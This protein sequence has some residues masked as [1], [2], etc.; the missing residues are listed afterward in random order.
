MCEIFIEA[1]QLSNKGGWVVDQQS[2]ETIHSSYL[3]AHGMGIPVEDATGEVEVAESGVYNIWV[4]TRDWTAVWDVKDSAG[5]FKLLVDGRETEQILGTN[6][7]E[8]GWQKAGEVEL[9]CGIH[10]IGL[11]DLTGFNGRCDAIYMTTGS[12]NP[13]DDIDSIRQ[14]L[15]W[16]EVKDGGEYELIVAG[17]GIAGICTAL[18]AIRGGVNALLI[19]DREVLGGCN[20]SEVR[21]CMGGLINLP[22]YPKLGDVV[23]EIAPVMGTPAKYDSRYF[24]DDRKLFA[25]EAS[26]AEKSVVFNECVTG[27]EKSGDNITAV[28]TTNVITGAKTRYKAKLFADCTG[29]AVLARLGGAEVMYGREARD[30]F[31]ETLAPIEYQKLVMGHSIR[32]YSEDK[33]EKT[34]FPDLKWGLEFNDKNCINTFSGD[35]EQETGFSRDMVKEA[36][37][38]RDFGLRAIYSNW[39][40]QKNHYCDKEKFENY[41]LKWVS[42]LGGK[43][44]SYRVVGEHILTQQDIEEHRIYDDATACLTWEIDMHF[45]ECDNVEEFG[46]PF[47]SF[48]YHR[49]IEKPYPVP[50]RCLYARDIKN[51]FLGGRTVSTSHVAFASVRVM[52]TLGMLGEVIGLASAIC[53][54]QNC[55]PSEVYSKHL[56]RLKAAMEKGVEIP[57]V[58]GWYPIDNEKYHIKESG[59]LNLNPPDWDRAHTEKFKRGIKALGIEHKYPLPE[60]F[61]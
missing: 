61:K 19:H 34:E 11:R 40:Y 37:Y 29:D 30:V 23:K 45:P 3:M 18:S 21:V 50:Y 9:S 47:R 58:F 42:A 13:S 36:E 33:G 31:G 2:M 22:P 16:K 25:F 57:T 59:W 54:E 38:I 12:E 20:S 35:W 60:E 53:R 39:A 5:K 26:N 48:A 52:R 17:G 24:E 28:I 55:L 51:L 4:R 7:A 32:W 44:E 6:G 43:R 46:E 1:E 14:R 8:W 56:D 15:S 27:I 10:E 41:S 49:G